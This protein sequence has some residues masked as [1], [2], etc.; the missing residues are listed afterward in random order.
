MNDNVANKKAALYVRVSTSHQVDKDSLPFQRKELI[1][2]SKYL[3]GIDDYEVFQDA[4]YSGKNTDRPA[5]QDMMRRVRKKE[6]THI[7][8]WKIDR[9]SRNLRDF[10]EMYDEVKK[11]G[12]TF[13]SKNEQFDTSSAMGEAML[14]II[15]VFAELERKLTGERVSS[16]MLS[17]AEKGLWNGAQC[18]L[19]YKWDDEKKFPIPDPDEAKVVQLIYDKYTEVKS[20]FKVSKVL[21]SDNVKTKRGGTWTSKTVVD[22]IRNPFYK[23]TYRYNYREAARGAIKDEKEW[24]IVDD[25]HEAIIPKEQWEHCNKIMNSN[26]ARNT[27]SLR[28]NSHVHPFSGLLECKQCGRGFI[29]SLDLARKDGY[30]PSIFRCQGKTRALGCEVGMISEITM[31]P[32]VIN[33]ISNFLKA[34]QTLTKKNNLKDFEKILLSGKTFKDVVGINTKD[35][36]SAYISILYTTDNILMNPPAKTKSKENISEL[37]VLG[38]EKEKYERAIERLQNLYLFSEESMPEKDF[39]V[40]KHNLKSKIDDIN[41]KIHSLHEQN[42]NH[43]AYNDISFLQK[44]SHFMIQNEL[45]NKKFIDYRNMSMVIDKQLIKDFMNT[46]IDKVIIDDRKVAG[47]CFK[48]GLTHNFIYRD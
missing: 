43:V 41:N 22:I 27:S 35:L 44:A 18:P 30:R 5:F 3:L 47:I 42:N 9:V 2:Y 17:R 28:R 6:F 7:L 8:V 38:K 25:N 11:Y 29:A 14:K 1:N 12:V 24:I 4:G 15:L 37:E 48:N 34:Q 39:L 33:Y 20:A 36:E 46:V 45:L 32:F 10:T 31:G 21:N 23:G 26:A 40:Q 16:I 13:I 19:G